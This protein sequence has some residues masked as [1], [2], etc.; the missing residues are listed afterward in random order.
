MQRSLIAETVNVCV[1]VSVF[2]VYLISLLQYQTEFAKMMNNKIVWFGLLC[3]IMQVSNEC[4]RVTAITHMKFPHLPLLQLAYS[5]HIQRIPRNDKTASDYSDNALP[6]A[7]ET[8]SV[9]S[10]DAFEITLDELKRNLT[11]GLPPDA[12][13]IVEGI[14]DNLKNTS[15]D[16]MK[17]VAGVRQTSNHYQFM[18]SF[19][20]DFVFFIHRKYC[21][22]SS[23]RL[24]SNWPIMKP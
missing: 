12:A 16:S 24:S 21:S 9:S 1:C 18:R 15:S 3:T 8:T 17:T 5:S 20:S 11:T 13:A 14:L 4:V 7:V 23:Y 19:C 2:G 10:D 22:C 6:T